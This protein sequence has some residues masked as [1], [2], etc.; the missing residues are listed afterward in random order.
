[1]WFGIL[2]ELGIPAFCVYLLIIVCA[3]AGCQRVATRAKRGEVSTELG[4]FALAFQTSFCVLAVGGT[5]VPWQ[6][7]EML[8]HFVGLST[9]LHTLGTATA[10]VPAAVVK[11]LPVPSGTFRRPQVMHGA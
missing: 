2:S 3:I 10:N 11:P 7:R 8:W 9:A 6:Y 4:Q 1:V 5:F